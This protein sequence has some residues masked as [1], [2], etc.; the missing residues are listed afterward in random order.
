MIAPGFA[1][2]ALARLAQ[3]L[4]QARGFGI[5]RD[6]SRALPAVMPRDGDTREGLV[7]LFVVGAH[8]TGMPLNKELTGAGGVFLREI[9][10]ARDYRLYVLPDTV[11]L[12]PGLQKAPGSDGPGILGEVW[13][14]SP[15]AFGQF[16]ARIP[17]PLGI[18]KVALADGTEVSG[19]LCEAHALA[20]AKEITAFG[21]WRRYIAS[22]T[23]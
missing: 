16:V 4:Q 14:L 20:D 3:R 8:L 9:R 2:P 23:A 15:E 19:F 13:A 18:G 5:G 21:G 11:P 12:K 1:D 17:A 7:S 22:R 10:T 6:K